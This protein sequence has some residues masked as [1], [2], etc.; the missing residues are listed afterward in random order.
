M[1]RDDIAFVLLIY[2]VIEVV[3]WW[4]NVHEL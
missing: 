4:N 3:N 2:S 1:L